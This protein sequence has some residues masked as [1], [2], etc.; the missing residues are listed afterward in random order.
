M[1]ALPPEN[2]NPSLFSLAGPLIFTTA[3]NAKS[4][5][6]ISQTEISFT[7]S[8]TPAMKPTAAQKKG[9]FKVHKYLFPYIKRII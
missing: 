6:A 3:K 9:I 2:K 8:P 1:R 7:P 4:K 5:I